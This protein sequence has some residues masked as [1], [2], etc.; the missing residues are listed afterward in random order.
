[1][2][3]RFNKG[4][5]LIEVIAALG[6]S[7][8][9]ITALVSL[10]LFTMR[11]SLQSK[12]LMNSTKSANQQLELVRAY[13]DSHSWAD[14]ILAMRNCD[15]APATVCRISTSQVITAAAPV[16]DAAFGPTTLD[17]YFVASNL[18]GGEVGEDDLSV[19]ISVTAKW[20]V[21]SALKTT[22]MYTEFTNWQNK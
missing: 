1:M 8:V 12:M 11:T 7:V 13:R 16:A 4:I 10:S 20:R 2:K 5:G 6:I 21:G 22:N 3:T 19:R 9:V 15:S 17:V 18:S 14:F